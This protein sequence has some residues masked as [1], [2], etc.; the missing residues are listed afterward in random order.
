MFTG[1][2]ERFRRASGV[3]DDM[4]AG[5]R[6][7]ADAGRRLA[8][9]ATITC[10]PSA[11]APW[12]RRWPTSRD[13]P[14]A[15]SPHRRGGRRAVV[16]RWPG[17]RRSAP[18]TGMRTTSPPLVASVADAVLDDRRGPDMASPAVGDTAPD[19]QLPGTGGR[20]YSLA[21]YRGPGRARL[22][23]R[24]QHAG[25][26]KAAHLVHAE[27]RAV[28]RRRRP[29]AGHQPAVGREPRGLRRQAR[30]LVPAPGRHRQ[31]GRRSVRHPRAARLPRRS[32]FVVDG[33][34]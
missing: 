21:E 8:P 2:T 25:V 28:R 24:R 23:P 11:C 34:G 17:R 26:H 27:H 10:A 22:L 13:R 31:E 7:G 32:V 12:S 1:G 5:A 4:A 33:G 9:T 18:I 6:L 16:H 14:R 30:L 15:P 20:S 19:F 29:G 3:D